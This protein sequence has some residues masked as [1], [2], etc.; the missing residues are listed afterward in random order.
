MSTEILDN[1]L[2]GVDT[3]ID[4][5]DNIVKKI[6]KEEEKL[7]I[8]IPSF[9]HHNKAPIYS[10]DISHDGKRFATAGGDGKVKIWNIITLD[11][12][13]NENKFPTLLCT[14]TSHMHAVN[15]YVLHL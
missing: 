13:K 14:L 15:V 2:N 12:E 3:T 7:L 1:Q 6:E 8:T 5:N 10:V 11:N 4:A 9:V